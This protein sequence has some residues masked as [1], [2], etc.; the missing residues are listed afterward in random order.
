MNGKD[1]K[2]H[3]DHIININQNKK[4]SKNHCIFLHKESF[5]GEQKAYSNQLQFLNMMS[6]FDIMIHPIEMR[7]K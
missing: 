1:F 3:L 6:F 5:D 2:S 7:R 4:K